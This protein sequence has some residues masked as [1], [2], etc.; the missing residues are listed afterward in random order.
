MI[1]I[2]IICPKNH[3]IDWIE[4]ATRFYLKKLKRLCTIDLVTPKESSFNKT[5]EKKLNYIALDP[6]AK[7]LT[8]EEFTEVVFENRESCYVIGPSNG[9]SQLQKSNANRLI[10]LSKLTFT[11]QQSSVILLEQIFRAF[12]IKNNKPYHK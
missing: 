8:S 11:H 2:Q 3:A 5:L 10:A 1:K 6:N 7:E 4:H 12:Q 9:L